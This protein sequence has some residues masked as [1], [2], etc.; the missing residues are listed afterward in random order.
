MMGLCALGSASKN[1]AVL[2][3]LEKIAQS[4][5]SLGIHC[6][7]TRIQPLLKLTVLL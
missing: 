1:E 7:K 5:L 6:R 4:R 2:G 3:K